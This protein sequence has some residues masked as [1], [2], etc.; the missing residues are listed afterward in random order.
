VADDFVGA[1]AIWRRH[2]FTG[3]NERRRHVSVF[4]AEPE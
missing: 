1:N 2:V 4:A 3:G